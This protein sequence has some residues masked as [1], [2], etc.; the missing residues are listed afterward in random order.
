MFLKNGTHA[1]EAGELIQMPNLA[2]TMEIISRQGMIALY[3]GSKLAKSFLADL[4]AAGKLQ[5]SKLYSVY[6]PDRFK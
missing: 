4:E 2:Q 5:D 6:F 1:Y 3:G